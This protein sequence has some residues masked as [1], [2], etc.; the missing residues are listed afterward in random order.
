LRGE[1]K[2]DEDQWESIASFDFLSAGSWG[3]ELLENIDR[4]F[5]LDMTKRTGP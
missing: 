4:R 1:A 2:T 5:R 3:E